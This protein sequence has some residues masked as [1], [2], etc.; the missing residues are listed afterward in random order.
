MASENP[1]TEAGVPADAHGA[2]NAHTE[3]PDDLHAGEKT[4]P[5]FDATTFA[6]Q[7]LWLAIT[8]ALLYWILAKYAIPRIGGI[9]AGRQERI[10]ADLTA[11]EQ[12]KAQSE[13]AQLAYE[14]ALA[15]ARTNAGRIAGG[16]RDEAKAASEKQRAS[17]EAETAKKLAAAE[18]R[19]GEIKDQAIAQVG[20]IAGDT[21]QA[22]VAA[23]ADVPVSRQEID[24]AVIASMRR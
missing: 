19:I 14:K 23:L 10:A 2:T 20:V 13:Q 1:E 15:E 22:V 8:F 5:P 21:A 7:L 24:D 11:A 12:L 16:A 6:S 4:F 18:A 9:I 3:Q 17:I